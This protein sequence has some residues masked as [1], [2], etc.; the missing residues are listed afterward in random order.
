MR[1]PPLTWISSSGGHQRWTTRSLPEDEA[2]L[3]GEQCGELHRK[4]GTEQPETD[5]AQP[6]R[7]F[8]AP[9]P[10]GIVLCEQQERLASVSD[11]PV[12]RH[13]EDKDH[14]Y[15]EHV[16]GEPD[17]IEP[18]GSH[19]IERTPPRLLAQEEPLVRLQQ[20]DQQEHADDDGD[21]D[22]SALGCRLADLVPQSHGLTFP[23][24]RS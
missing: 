10:L 24:I 15:A 19:E 17:P 18:I 21:L 13:T 12:G 6:L 23:R 14:Y 7:A 22:P 1:C 3:A 9:L 5:H 2:R 20:D 11:W 16:Q 8:G 4:A